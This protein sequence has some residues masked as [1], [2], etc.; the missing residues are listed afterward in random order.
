MRLRNVVVIKAGKDQAYLQHVTGMGKKCGSDQ[1]KVIWW[2]G[3]G[4]WREA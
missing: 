4:M 1:G 2:G 3:L